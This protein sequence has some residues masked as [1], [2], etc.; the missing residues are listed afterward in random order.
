MNVPGEKDE[1]R[2]VDADRRLDSLD[3]RLDRLQASE[4]ARTGRDKPEADPNYRMGNRVLADLIGGIAGGALIGWLVDRW[5]GSWP[6]GFLIFLALGI[7][8]AFRN[9]FRIANAAS[10]SSGDAGSE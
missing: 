5:F 9:I 6:V 2:Q 8:V 7:V 10:R 3:E 1:F 4:V